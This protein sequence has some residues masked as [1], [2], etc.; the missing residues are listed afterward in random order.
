MTTPFDVRIEN[1]PDYLDI[2]VRADGTATVT[3]GDWPE[4]ASIELDPTMLNVLRAA[5][6]PIP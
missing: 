3:I 1:G 5:L 4:L 6:E 2:V